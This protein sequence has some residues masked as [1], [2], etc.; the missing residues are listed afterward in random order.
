MLGSAAVSVAMT[1]EELEGHR[2]SVGG[3]IEGVEEFI[4]ANGRAL[5]RCATEL[6]AFRAAT[7]AIREYMAQDPAQIDK[8]RLLRL[9]DDLS[10]SIQALLACM[11]VAPPVGAP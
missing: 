2:G 5:M 7:Q 6:G 8:F 4:R 3:A 10:R 9:I 11:G 1:A